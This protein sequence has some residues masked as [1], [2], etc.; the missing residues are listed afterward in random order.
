MSLNENSSL[1]AG[2]RNR[3]T[4]ALTGAALG[5]ALTGNPRYAAFGGVAGYLLGGNEKSK[6][7]KRSRTRKVKKS[8]SLKKL[9][10][11]RKTRRRSASRQKITRR[12]ISMSGGYNA[13]D[14]PNLVKI[15]IP[16]PDDNAYNGGVTVRHVNFQTTTIGL[17]FQKVRAE[18]PADVPQQ[19]YLE[20]PVEGIIDE[21]GYSH[22]YIFGV[23]NLNNNDTLDVFMAKEDLIERQMIF[24]VIFGPSPRG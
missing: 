10:S 8:S 20:C 3:V 13:Q 15:I 16:Q 24:I 11:K 21:N 9:S 14:F 4:N 2:T 1:E 7:R 5:Y 18:L 23:G 17:L 12:R 22:D 6:S 19:F